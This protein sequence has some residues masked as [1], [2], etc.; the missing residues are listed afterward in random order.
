MLPVSRDLSWAV[1]Q[2]T[3][4][5]S[6]HRVSLCGLLW[7]FS[8]SDAWVPSE[9]P[10]GARW[11]CAEFLGSSFRSHTTSFLPRSLGWHDKVL[12]RFKER[13]HRSH[14][15]VGEWS[16]SDCKKSMWDGGYWR[17][18]LKNTIYC[19]V[20]LVGQCFTCSGYSLAETHMCHKDTHTLCPLL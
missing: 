12:P 4:T 19:I 11:K 9:H 16:R 18:S 20:Y 14:H 5:C 7:A 8:Q 10:K 15:S 3:Y 1:G 17:P 6:F 13:E 2:N